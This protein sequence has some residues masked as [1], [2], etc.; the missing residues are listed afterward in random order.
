M[1]RNFHVLAQFPFTT[2][3]LDYYHKKVTIRVASRVAYGLKTKDLT[4]LEN[5]QKIAEMLG[6]DDEYQMA[7]FGSCS[8]KLR[9]TICKTFN[10][11]TDFTQFQHFTIFFP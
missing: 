11:K 9:Q 2:R 1:C 8:R 5:F 3:E 4:K 6:T 7:N 10:R